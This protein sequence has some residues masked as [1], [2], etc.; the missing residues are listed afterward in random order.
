MV[1]S[2]VALAARSTGDGGFRGSAILQRYVAITL[3]WAERASEMVGRLVRK[4]SMSLERISRSESGMWPLSWAVVISIT[5]CSSGGRSIA[6]DGRVESELIRIWE[7]RKN[8]RAVLR[9]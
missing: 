5:E 6:F 7:E 9:L 8:S 3:K 4:E 2:V 1:Y